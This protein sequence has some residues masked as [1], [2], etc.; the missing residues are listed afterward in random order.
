MARRGY[1]LDDCCRC[2]GMESVV[3][4][5]DAGADM[6]AASKNIATA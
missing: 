6:N 3:S 4:L 5:I 2:G 1:H